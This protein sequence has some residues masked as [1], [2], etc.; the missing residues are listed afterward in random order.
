MLAKSHRTGPQMKPYIR[1]TL[2][3]HD[4]RRKIQEGE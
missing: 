4:E 1:I 2:E 3:Y